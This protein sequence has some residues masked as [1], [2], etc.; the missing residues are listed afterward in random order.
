M[1]KVDLKGEGMD[2]GRS[3]TVS[4]GNVLFAIHTEVET[5]SPVRIVSRVY[6]GGEVV[7]TYALDSLSAEKALKQSG[8]S[9][10]VY[11]FHE[12]S[13][14]AFRS[15]KR[16]E[17]MG[18]AQFVMRAQ[19][20]MKSYELR[21][22]YKLVTEGLGRYPNNMFLQSYYGLLIVQVQKD[23]RL[24]IATCLEAIRKAK[25]VVGCDV[26]HVYPALYVNLGK[27]YL[28]AGDR[29]SAYGAFDR[30]MMTGGRHP[31][32]EREM[33]RLG[34]RRQP[35]FPFLE[36]SNPLN[37]YPGMVLHKLLPAGV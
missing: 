36:R 28:V 18:P 15:D 9:I 4:I 13:V 12:Q 11:N 10:V 24:G 33:I 32:A 31:E 19:E 35:L 20:Y 5:K 2:E 21:K 23:R 14:A 25:E 7:A 3:S 27:A 8:L 1:E 29:A 17:A 37:K 34:L 22:A 16:K 26:E 6:L 30:V